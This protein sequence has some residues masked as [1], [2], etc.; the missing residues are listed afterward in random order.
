VI[1]ESVANQDDVNHCRAVFAAGAGQ[2]EVFSTPGL[3]AL[4]V[5]TAED[6]SET[7][8]VIVQIEKQV[9]GSMT[10]VGYVFPQ[11]GSG[12]GVLEDLRILEFS[13]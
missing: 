1:E 6:G 2:S 7:K 4:A 13:K 3:P 10:V 8:V 12:M 5:L 11:G 9:G